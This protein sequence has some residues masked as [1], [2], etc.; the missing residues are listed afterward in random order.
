MDIKV[1]VQGTDMDKT[2]TEAKTGA[3][4]V[5]IVFMPP[6]CL[7]QMEADKAIVR[8]AGSSALKNQDLFRATPR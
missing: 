8:N 7:D 2:V 3:L 5:D 1:T 4:P 6:D